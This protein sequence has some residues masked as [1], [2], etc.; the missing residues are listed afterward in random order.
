MELWCF[1]FS[2]LLVTRIQC[3]K[4]NHPKSAF[5]RL[6]STR[7][8]VFHHFPNLWMKNDIITKLSN[9]QPN[10]CHEFNDKHVSKSHEE[11]TIVVPS[12]RYFYRHN[13][14][15]NYKQIA[16]SLFIPK[17]STPTYFLFP[18]RLNREQVE[19]GKHNLRQ[20]KHWKLCI[21]PLHLDLLSVVIKTETIR[22]KDEKIETKSNLS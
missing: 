21:W 17:Y 16:Q 5:R 3:S 6:G 7:L 12:F 13:S 22:I 18:R 9:L 2:Y 14:V 20:I 8:R 1:I 15:Q 10:L 19:I 4:L 11:F